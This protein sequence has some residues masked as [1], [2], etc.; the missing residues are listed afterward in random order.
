MS[1]PIIIKTIPPKGYHIF[2]RGK[3]GRV[4]ML[5]LV[6]TGA[7]KSVIDT[8]FAQTNFPK[9]LIKIT[10][11]LTTG[12]GANI[13]NSSFISLHRIKIGDT[14]IKPMEFALLDLDMVNQAYASADLD[15]VV[16][17]IGGDV[18]KKYGAIIDYN[19]QTLHLHP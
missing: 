3:I 17:I 7:S 19:L 5:F 4:K 16:A 18:L 1:I 11:H 6:D 12:L 2:V 9:G 14:K 10:D 13:P 8:T 15:P